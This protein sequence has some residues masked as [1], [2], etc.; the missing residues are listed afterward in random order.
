VPGKTYFTYEITWQPDLR[1]RG[2]RQDW[3][4]GVGRWAWAVPSQ[5]HV[6]WSDL[7]QISWCAAVCKRE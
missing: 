1:R 6:W 2:W 4:L 7:K 5:V 3:A